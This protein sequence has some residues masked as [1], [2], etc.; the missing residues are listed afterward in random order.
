MPKKSLQTAK[1]LLEETESIKNCSFMESK[2]FNLQVFDTEIIYHPT[3]NGLIF[4][5]IVY[6][7]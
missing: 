3:Y 7:G 1:P 2:L 5:S 4:L 6:N